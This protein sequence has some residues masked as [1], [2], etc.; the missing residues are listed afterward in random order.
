MTP[1]ER[2]EIAA[3]QNARGTLRKTGNPIGTPVAPPEA[4]APAP[5][6]PQ[7]NYSTNL[8]IFGDPR[9]S[10]QVGD[11]F[12]SPGEEPPPGTPEHDEWRR[13]AGAW[14]RFIGGRQNY[15]NQMIGTGY[16]PEDLGIFNRK[17]EGMAGYKRLTAPGVTEG[18]HRQAEQYMR[19]TDAEVDPV[20][21][22]YR[23]GSGPTSRYSDAR[24]MNVNAQGQ[25]VGG[26]YGMANTMGQFGLGAI[27]RSSSA[28]PPAMRPVGGRA[29]GPQA[30]AATLTPRPA[31]RAAYA[32][33]NNAGWN[34]RNPRRPVMPYGI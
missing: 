27:P 7:Y 17:E 10:Y 9:Y 14:R 18:L 19:G 31:A 21:G 20:T 22:F 28:A 16:S 5:G 13:H 6:T 3:N 24:G 30:A 23:T 15:V 12:N 4:Q 33:Q 1:E 25:R 8:G 11:E 32:P 34:I 26:F 2:R 29:E